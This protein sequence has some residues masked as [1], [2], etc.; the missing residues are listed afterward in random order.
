M[1]AKLGDIFA[2]A[3][4]DSSALGRVVRDAVGQ[5]HRRS[6]SRGDYGRIDQPER[7]SARA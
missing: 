4:F 1:K 5:G 2:G 7:S 3:A 6:D